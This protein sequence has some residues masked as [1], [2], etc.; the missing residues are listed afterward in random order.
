MCQG[1][2]GWPWLIR[3]LSFSQFCTWLNACPWA[4]H[5]AS[6]CCRCSGDEICQLY[7]VSLNLSGLW[8]KNRRGPGVHVRLK[9]MGGEWPWELKKCPWTANSNKSGFIVAL[10]H[11]SSG[12][13]GRFLVLEFS[14]KRRTAITSPFVYSL[15]RVPTPLCFPCPAILTTHCCYLW[16]LASWTKT[17]WGRDLSTPCNIVPSVSS[18]CLANR[19]HA[20]NICWMDEYSHR[21]YPRFCFTEVAYS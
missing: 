14:K 13:W 1:K 3:W 5:W 17:T 9:L 7:C 10:G 21:E 16:S 4:S 19:S 6:S 12:P 15:L 8:D 20:S 2:G 11:L 18:T